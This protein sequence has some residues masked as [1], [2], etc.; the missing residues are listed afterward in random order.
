MSDGQISPERLDQFARSKMVRCAFDHLIGSNC[1]ARV[2]M[3]LQKCGALKHKLTPP[4]IPAYVIAAIR[5]SRDAGRLPGPA[6]PIVLIKAPGA[7]EEAEAVSMLE[8]LCAPHQ[9]ARDA[10][11]THLER[12][13]GPSGFLTPFSQ[14]LL[15]EYAADI[16]AD[17]P[18]RW[19]TPAMR[20]ERELDQDFKCNLAGYKAG[21]VVGNRELKV[22]YWSRLLHP[23]VASFLSTDAD[24]YSLCKSRVAAEAAIAEIAE[25]AS[26]ITDVLSGYDRVLGHLPL[27]AEIDVGAAVARYSTRKPIGGQWP[28]VQAWALQSAHPLRR[29][30]A[31][32]AV[33]ANSCLLPSDS[34]KSYWSEFAA[35]AG[36]SE[37][38]AESCGAAKVLEFEADLARHYFRYLEVDSPA[39]DVDKLAA[40]AWWAARCVTDVVAEDVARTA[41]PS[42]SVEQMQELAL[43]PVSGVSEILWQ[44][45][46][47]RSGESTIRYATL[48]CHQPRVLGLMTRMAG[49]ASALSFAGLDEDRAQ[50][51]TKAFVQHQSACFPIQSRPEN[52]AIWAFDAALRPA[53]EEWVAAARP[54]SE[55]EALSGIVAV[56]AAVEN[57]G[58]V[59]GELRALPDLSDRV[60]ICLGHVFRVLSYCG[61]GSADALWALMR[62]ED[63]RV[64]LFRGA[65]DQAMYAVFDGAI[66][67]AH[68]LGSDER[69]AL[70]HYF[71][72]LCELEEL[73]PD[74]RSALVLMTVIAATS[75]NCVSAVRKL[76]N[77][78]KC[79]HLTADIAQCR[80]QIQHMLA[81]APPAL[82]ATFRDVL[83]SLRC[84]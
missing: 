11:L 1:D 4:A 75:L 69:R 38:G 24:A 29:L 50:A 14:R 57:M 9:E 3:L 28:E 2:A 16:R 80:E 72:D 39:L 48:F 36:F 83:S 40:A 64:Q 78:T 84:A 10:A 76:V 53:F 81:V 47:P 25:S 35:L 26:C 15:H 79:S 18:E 23:S 5:D 77:S 49:S 54:A 20:L 61:H 7:T 32:C 66:E 34:S 31:C 62:D 43:R 12:G 63:W 71:A 65:P 68:K 46:H 30:Q 21:V 58:K 37:G 19:L 6:G 55:Q 17:A 67:L 52:E 33:I 56:A 74:R 82:T 22:H 27:R 51:I 70:P 45:A 8:L 42:E 73:A 44:W 60:S 59:A 13:V 41:C